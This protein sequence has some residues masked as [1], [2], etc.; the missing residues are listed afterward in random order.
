MQVSPILRRADDFFMHWCPSCQEMHPLP[1]NG[2]TFNGD[3]DRPT[4]YPSFKHTLPHWTGGVDECGVGQGARQDRICHYFIRNGQIQF[5]GDSWHKRSDIVAMP[6]I[7]EAY[8][9]R[10]E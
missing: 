10:S 1:L 6:Q 2:W 4:F 9:D 8:A 3:V 7:P 5:C